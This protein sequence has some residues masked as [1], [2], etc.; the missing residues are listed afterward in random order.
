MDAIT[1]NVSNYIKRMGISLTKV[2]KDTGIPY[3]ALY[4]SLMNDKRNRQLRGTELIKVC[5][6]LGI[7]PMKFAEQGQEVV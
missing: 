5:E 2:S 1:I 7:D 6:F 3:M 4:D